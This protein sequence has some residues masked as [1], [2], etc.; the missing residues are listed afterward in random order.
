MCMIK[1]AVIFSDENRNKKRYKK[2]AVNEITL[3]RDEYRNIIHEAYHEGRIDA[4]KEQKNHDNKPLKSRHKEIVQKGKEE[5]IQENAKEKEANKQRVEAITARHEI[6]LLRTQS[7]FPF[8]IFTDTLIIDT[9]KVTIAK[10]QLVA[11][12]YIITIPLK[13]I[14]DVTVQTVLF[15]ATLTISYMPQAASSGGGTPVEVRIP[16]LN[17]SD[18]INAKNILKGVLVADA[19]EI[20]IADLSPEEVADV[21]QKFGKSKGVI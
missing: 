10:K 6:E 7:V 12:E 20:N 16:N 13:D 3:S 5:A 21:L 14:S 19:E 17:R 4:L 8:T 9:T 2:S 15:L 18:A 11:T 1:S